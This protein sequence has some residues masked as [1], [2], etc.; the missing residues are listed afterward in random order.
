MGNSQLNGNCTRRSRCRSLLKVYH[1]KGPHACSHRVGGGSIVVILA[2]RPGGPYGSLD[3]TERTVPAENLG[4]QA[5]SEAEAL[6]DEVER[7]IC[8]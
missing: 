5:T 6:L 4:Q 3:Q 7:R 8:E 2:W 1:K